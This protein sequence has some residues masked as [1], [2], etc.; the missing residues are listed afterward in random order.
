MTFLAQVLKFYWKKGKNITLHTEWGMSA[1]WIIIQWE[2]NYA[3]RHIEA[4]DEMN[5][6]SPSMSKSWMSVDQL[7][8]SAFGLREQD[9]GTN[10]C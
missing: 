4:D 7:R 10:V 5:Q 3:L 2:M 1:V 8:I 9:V 6:N